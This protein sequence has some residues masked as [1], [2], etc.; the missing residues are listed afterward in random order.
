MTGMRF[1]F[2]LASLAL[3]AACATPT[4]SSPAGP[5][6]APVTAPAPSS[7]G[8]HAAQLL[9]SAGQPN[10]AT[11][12]DIE[13]AFGAADIARQDGA[14]LSLTYRLDSCALLLLFAPDARSAMRLREAH[15]DPRHPGA[16]AP[17]AEQ[18]AT[19]ASA[20]RR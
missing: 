19:E 15:I 20:R 16:T 1:A 10:A 9:A 11:R 7:G 14:G 13:R 8:S 4:S 6:S 18:C 12:A 2:V 3:L 5:A 17:S